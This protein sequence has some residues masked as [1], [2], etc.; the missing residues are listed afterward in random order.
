MKEA[1]YFNTEEEFREWFEKNYEKLG[2]KRIILSQAVCPDYVVEMQDGRILKMEAELFAVNFKYHGHDPS[3]AHL[4]LACY[5]REEEVTGVPVIPVNRLWLFEEEPLSPLPSEGPLSDDESELLAAVMLSGGREISSFGQGRFSGDKW[6]FKAF[7]PE[8][9]ASFPRGKIQDSIF[10]VIT[11]KTKRYIKRYHH[12]LIG[13]NLSEAACEAIE[14]LRRRDLIRA[15]PIDIA[16]ALY[17]GVLVDHDGW[18]PT[19][20]YATQ[21]A[22]TFH[23]KAALEYMR[24]CLSTRKQ[25][26]QGTRK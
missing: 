17:D 19:E 2:V 15:R 20:L 16:S 3:K 14:K 25:N 8:M 12:I 26:P 24:S 22:K 10:N 13:V 18:V 4:I 9:V 21:T 5:A 23:R 7:P 6:L 1:V 11:E